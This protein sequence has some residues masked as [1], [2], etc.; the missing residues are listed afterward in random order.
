VAGTAFGIGSPTFYSGQPPSPWGF[1]P[2]SSQ[3]GFTS[4]PQA[5]PLQSL[6]IVAQQLHQLEYL[7]QQQIQ[8]LQQVVQVVSY[9]LHQLQQLAQLVPQQ[10]QQLQQQL[11]AQQ[12]PFS[13]GMPGLGIP[14]AGSGAGWLGAQ[15]FSPQ[16]GQVM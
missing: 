16:P 8:Q 12:T 6:Q 15:A 11:Q 3:L 13:G 7:Q 14:Y 4:G 2:Y 9:Q 1:S 5:Q 10:I